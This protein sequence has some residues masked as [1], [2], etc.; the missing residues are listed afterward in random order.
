MPKSSVGSGNSMYH[1]CNPSS[2]THSRSIT[3]TRFRGSHV[4]H[5][6]RTHSRPI[7]WQ[8]RYCLAS[9]LRDSCAYQCECGKGVLTSSDVSPWCPTTNM[10]NRAAHRIHKSPGLGVEHIPLAETV[11]VGHSPSH[12]NTSTDPQIERCRFLHAAAE[13]D[14]A[15]EDG[16]CGHVVTDGHGHDRRGHGELHRRGVNDAH[17][18]A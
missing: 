13:D 7:I 9:L 8:E 12:A 6:T 17:D 18:V 11:T 1:V 10:R 3:C 15:A 14:V 4:G 16:A 2:R 5:G